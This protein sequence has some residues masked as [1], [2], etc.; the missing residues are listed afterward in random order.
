MLFYHALHVPKKRCAISAKEYDALHEP[1][2]HV[3]MAAK[4]MAC[5]KLEKKNRCR[6]FWREKRNQKSIEHL[7]HVISLQ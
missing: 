5:R 3:W 1:L 4:L 6:K 2:G 7:C